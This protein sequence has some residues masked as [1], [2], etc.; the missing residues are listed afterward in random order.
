[1]VLARQLLQQI[2]HVILVPRASRDACASVDVAVSVS[3]CLC[4]FLVYVCVSHNPRILVK[5][6]P[7][8]GLDSLLLLMTPEH[9][10]GLYNL[11]AEHTAQAESALSESDSARTLR[12]RPL[13]ARRHPN[14]PA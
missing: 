14:A 4:L 9:S 3:L 8:V 13:E 2:S 5:T 7:R 6:Y 11:V 12:T 10:S 1:M